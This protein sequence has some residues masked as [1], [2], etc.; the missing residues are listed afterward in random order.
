V[1]IGDIKIA[2]QKRLYSLPNGGFYYFFCDAWK[3]FEPEKLEPTLHMRYLCDMA[4]REVERIVANQP[5]TSHI[6]IKVPPRTAK[7]STFSIALNAWAWSFAP[8]LRIMSISATARLS[9][10]MSLKTRRLILSKWYRRLYGDVYKLSRD[11]NTGS[12]FWNDKNGVRFATSATGTITGDGADIVITDDLIS[13][14]DARS[15]T[16]LEAANTIFRETIYN[17]L[18]NPMVGVHIVIAQRLAAGDVMGMIEERFKDE[19][20]SICLP[21]EYTQDVHPPECAALYINGLL[22]PSR[23]P[24]SFLNSIRDDVQYYSAQY[25]QQP[26]AGSGNLFNADDM[27]DFSLQELVSYA[28]GDGVDLFWHASIDGAMTDKTNSDFTCAI[29]WTVFRNR[30]FI[31]DI[32]F[33]KI[34]PSQYDVLARF[35]TKNRIGSKSMVFVEPKASGH[36]VIDLLVTVYGINAKESFAPKGSKV[37]RASDVSKYVSS[38]RVC[39]AASA[40][41]RK[42]FL[43]QVAAFPFTAKDDGVDALIIAI[44]HGLVDGVNNKISDINIIEINQSSM[45]CHLTICSLADRYYFTISQRINGKNYFVDLGSDVSISSIIQKVIEQSRLY[46]GINTFCYYG[47]DRRHLSNQINASIPRA[48]NLTTSP[49]G[50]SAMFSIAMRDLPRCY[51]KN[52]LTELISSVNT[53]EVSNFNKN[54][55]SLCFCATLISFL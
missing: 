48:K 16:A 52:G 55:Y 24:H 19:F 54:G 28:A 32:F 25:L 34:L 39:L 14:T 38:K 44:K 22:S 2:A 10:K 29:V 13:A 26:I 31:R 7:S 47:D 4:Q 42:M 50:D 20:T 15:K 11:K 37:E 18:N 12:E 30:L 21:A 8:H 43:D 36:A 1:H 45:G 3:E 5:R 41:N 51:F 23:M 40:T 53:M 9:A 49:R 35:L 27:V 17:R 6:A 46:G 33:G